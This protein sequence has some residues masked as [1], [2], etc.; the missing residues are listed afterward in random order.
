MSMSRSVSVSPLEMKCQKVASFPQYFPEYAGRQV[1]CAVASVYLDPS[2]IAFLN[3]EKLY[4]IAMGDD[5]M[6]VVNLGQF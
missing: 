1:L 5:T 6:E 2:V 3:R 4:G